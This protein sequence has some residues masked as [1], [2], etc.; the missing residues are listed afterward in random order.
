MSSGIRSYFCVWDNPHEI[1]IR[2]SDGNE[3]D[4]L[5]SEFSDLEPQELCDT[6]LK[7]WVD[8]AKKAK[9]YGYVAY[10]ISAKGLHHLHMVLESTTNIEF[11]SVKKVFPRAHIEV[12]R[13]KKKE[14][15]DY[16]NKRGKYEEKGEIVVCHSQVGE[17]KGNQGKRSDLIAIEEELA[18]GKTPN[19]IIGNSVRRQRYAGM[20]QAAYMAK[21]ESECPI[22]RDVMVYWH[23]DLP[24]PGN[25]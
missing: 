8:S 21:R 10:C 17:L 15:E 13:A 20:I 2:D 19:E 9:R 1:I 4:R 6:V 18:L 5:P 12:T 24:V 23:Y 16:V 11:S 22:E 25:P 3:I 7:L 14:F